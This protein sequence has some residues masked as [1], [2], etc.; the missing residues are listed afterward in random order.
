MSFVPITLKITEKK[1]KKS[2]S[3]YCRLE[4]CRKKQDVLIGA[5]ILSL[6]WST[7]AMSNQYFKPFCI[8]R[9]VIFKL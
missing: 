5:I 3:C 4:I 2:W 6:F 1:A 9:I 7:S 8:I